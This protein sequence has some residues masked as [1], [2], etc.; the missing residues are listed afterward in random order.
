MTELQSEYIIS[1][2][3]YIVSKLPQCLINKEL[4]KTFLQELDIFHWV[5]VITHDNVKLI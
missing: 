5:E 3:N 2:E 1:S 4:Y